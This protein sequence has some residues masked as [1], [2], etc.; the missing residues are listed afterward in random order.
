MHSL[1]EI[2]KNIFKKEV[3]NT[4]IKEI[5]AEDCMIA[6][7]QIPVIYL[8]DD[9]KEIQE[10]ISN[11]K[12]RYFLVCNENLDNIVGVLDIFNI[13]LFNKINLHLE[14]LETPCFV[15]EN[16]E[17]SSIISEI[18]QEKNLFVVIDE[19]GGTKGILNIQ[20]VMQY[21]SDSFQYEELA[22]DH[23]VTINGNMSIDNLQKIITIPNI[24][25][26]DSKTVNGF[27]MEYLGK[28][29]KHNENFEINKVN[30][31]I[32]SIEERQIQEIL[33]SKIR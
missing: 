24:D 32:L 13:H 28:I 11:G 20:S 10:I 3:K 22:F 25:Q 16:T 17:I 4:D 23:P 14:K 5:V 19:F 29:P 7:S 21:V 30:F 18:I 27:I 9:L 6:R 26:Y 2:F 12:Q 33:L 1:L 31:K 8:N 15:A